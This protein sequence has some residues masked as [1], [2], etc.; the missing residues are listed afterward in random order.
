MNIIQ[1]DGKSSKT[2]PTISFKTAE[3]TVLDV[4]KWHVM[5]SY[6]Q[7]PFSLRGER[8]LSDASKYSDVVI[9]SLKVKRLEEKQMNPGRSVHFKLCS[10]P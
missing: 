7:E 9:K 5:S 8:S 3:R 10:Y 6:E 4:R 2:K 1:S